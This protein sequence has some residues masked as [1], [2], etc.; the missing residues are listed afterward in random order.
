[1]PESIIFNII[2][3][4]LIVLCQST[5]KLCMHLTERHKGTLNQYL[6][7][8]SFIHQYSRP[9]IKATRFKLPKRRT[10]HISNMNQLQKALQPIMIK[11]LD[12]LY[13]TKIRIFAI[14]LYCVLEIPLCILWHSVIG[15]K[16]GLLCLRN[17]I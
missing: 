7:K 3:S 1:M 13:L 2:L 14:T 17:I 4:I 8:T 15:N 16:E 9:A 12:Q 5:I 6:K 11:M 10:K